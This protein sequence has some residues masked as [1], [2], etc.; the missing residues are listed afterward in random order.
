MEKR[1]AKHIFDKILNIF[2]WLSFFVAVIISLTVLISTYSG[3]QNGKTIFGYKMLIV[4]S[5]SMVLT[6]DNKDEPISFTVGDLIIIDEVSDYS[7]IKVGDVITF[8]SYNPDSVGKTISHKVRSIIIADSGAIIGFETYGIATGVSDQAIVEPSTIIGRYVSKVSKL[9]HLFSFFKTPAGYFTS[10]LTPCV[11]LIIFFSIQVGKFIARRELANS[12][13]FELEKL[14][15]KLLELE[16]KKDGAIMQT[17]LDEIAFTKEQVGAVAEQSVNSESP[18]VESRQA[19]GQ[20][21]YGFQTAQPILQVP[22]FNDKA[23]ELTVNALNNTIDTLTR[24]IENLALAVN[25]PVDTLA[26]TVETLASATI[27]P[28]VVEKIVEV[29][30]PQP[31]VEVPVAPII[32]TPAIQSQDKTPIE[33]VTASI[34]QTNISDTQ[35]S[36]FNELSAVREKVPFNKK[37]LSL[38]S[39]IKKYFSEVHNELIS[40]KKVNYRISFKGVTYRVGRNAIAKMMVRGK[41]LKLHLALKVDDYPKAVYFQEDSSDVKMYEDVPFAVKIKSNRAKN[42]AIKLVTY[43]AENNNLVKKEEFK[44][45]NVLK[46]LKS[47]K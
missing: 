17:S 41:T 24:T 18:T 14:K 20:T 27:K 3:T 35:P 5:D 36:F 12:Y 40:Y 45:V 42:N 1:K 38:D 39:E 31:Q 8:I 15:D 2:A 4:E 43:I 7:T 9:G 6:E 30:V 13:D 10:I 11:L 37:L 32:E 34:P 19:C 33:S 46:E 28:T 44:A 26:R 29:P 47:I 22:T 23:L 25:K 16:R 21:Q